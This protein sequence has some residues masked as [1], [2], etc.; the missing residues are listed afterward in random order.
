VP[1]LVINVSNI[2]SPLCYTVLR[3]EPYSVCPYNCVYCYSR[4]YFKSRP[5]VIA[6]RMK[7]V[8]MFERVV[9]RIYKMGARPIPFRLSTLVEP[10]PPHEELNRISE[11]VLNIAKRYEY[12]LIVNTKSVKAVEIV[13]VRK[14]LEDLL[15]KSLAVLQ[16]SLST[17]DDDKARILE[18]L[19]PPPMRRLD[20]IKEFGLR[21]MPIVI[22]LSPFIPFYSPTSEED[23]KFTLGLFK[24]IGV[25][26]I[27]VEALR[28]EREAAETLV[29]KLGD[30]ELSFEGYSIRE[31]EGLKPLVRV[32][33]RLRIEAYATLHRHAVKNGIGFA[34][35]KEGLFRF[36]T[37]D[38]CCGAYMLKNYALRVT[39]WDLYRAGI[40]VGKQEIDVETS[41]TS[42]CK[43]FL[44][45]CSELLSLYPRAI[46]KPLKYHE[47]KLLKVLRKPEL[48]KHIA[49]DIV[50]N[51]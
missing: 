39:L 45:I 8:E 23:I 25:K 34:T 3:I 30:H 14:A 18:P 46:S 7:A 12:P 27:I 44:R 47:K 26:H 50:N 24:D 9:K 49:P 31:V 28:I 35:C 48:L 38:D 5:D 2:I 43:K 36:H 15:D 17:L 10:F 51:T 40:I 20:M 33:E 4:W 42:I 19:A 32:S 37:V 29:K 16:L 41:I 21:G 11:R 22:R 13:G 1:E 6:P